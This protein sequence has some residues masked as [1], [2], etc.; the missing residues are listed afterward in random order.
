MLPDLRRADEA[1]GR[2]MGKTL[3]VV[4]LLIACAMARWVSHSWGMTLRKAIFMQEP[5]WSLALQG[6]INQ[7]W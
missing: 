5:A 4:D 1:K 7:A 3:S 6:S 2:I